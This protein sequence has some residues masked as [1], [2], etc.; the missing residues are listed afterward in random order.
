M[1]MHCLFMMIQ[2]L[3]NGTHLDDNMALCCPHCGAPSTI[4][5]LQSGCKY[6]GTKFIMS[7]LYPKVMNY[8]IHERYISERV[9]NKNKRDLAILITAC[10]IPMIIIAIISNVFFSQGQERIMNIILAPISGIFAG[11]MIGGMIFLFKNALII[12]TLI[13]YQLATI[14]TP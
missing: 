1:H 12:M 6:C 10:S 5:M 4:S 2:E 7:E 8:M 11:A 13:L 3:K 14:L 9:S